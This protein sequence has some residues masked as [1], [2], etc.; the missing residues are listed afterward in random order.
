MKG[1]P[2]GQAAVHPGGP[3]GEHGGEAHGGNEDRNHPPDNH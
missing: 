3:S 1:G 2:Q